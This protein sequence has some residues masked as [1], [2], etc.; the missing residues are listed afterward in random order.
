MASPTSSS[1]PIAD[2][3]AAVDVE[4]IGAAPAVAVGNLCQATAQALA[5]AAHNATANQQQGNVLAQ[6]VNAVGVALVYS[7]KP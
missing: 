2:A 7:Y 5:N 3:L 1:S 6:A 4:V